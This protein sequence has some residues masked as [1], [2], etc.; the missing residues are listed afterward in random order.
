[1][2]PASGS[3]SSPGRS[4]CPLAHRS[5]PST[6]RH[7]GAP[8]YDSRS[9]TVPV[10]PP[11]PSP[12]RRR[13]SSEGRITHVRLVASCDRRRRWVG[14]AGVRPWPDAQVQRGTMN[15][16]RNVDVIRPPTMTTAIGCSISWPGRLPAITKGTTASPVARAVI[17]IGDSRSWRPATRA[18][19][20]R[21][22]P[23]GVSRCWKWLIIMIPV[24]RGDTEHREEPHKRTERDRAA[25]QVDGEHAARQG[26]RA[27]PGRRAR[28]AASCAARRRRRRKTPS[29]AASANRSRRLCAVCRSAYSPEQLRVVAEREIDRRRAAASMSLTTE[30]RSRPSTF[31]LDV[32]APRVA[33]AFDRVRRRLRRGRR[34]PA[35]THVPAAGRVEEEIAD[36]GQAVARFRRAPDVA[37]RRPSRRGRCRRP[38]RRTSR[39]AA[40][41]RT[42]PGLI[43]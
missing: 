39:V 4:R 38:P 32:D 29:T 3:R 16:L 15:R 9:R 37:R 20:R 27:G 31:A 6:G 19:G 12:P 23:R 40:A 25:G 41:R 7:A 43:P 34:R 22:P 1:M 36:V 5:G 2:S 33:L 42:S 30:P 18:P 14:T 17:R 24:A 35:Q 26:D 10:E 13:R 8:P 21:S 11:A 28:P